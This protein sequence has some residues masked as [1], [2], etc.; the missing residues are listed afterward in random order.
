[1]KV[2]KNNASRLKRRINCGMHW[3]T[4]TFATGS[5]KWTSTV[6]PRML[7]EGGI[8]FNRERYD[9]L[10]QSGIAAERGTA[11][12]Y[13]NVRRSDNSL[14]YI[15]GASAAQ[16]GNYPDRYNLTGS[17][18]YVTG[19]HS[20]KAGFIDGFGPYRRYNNAN[21]DLYQIYNNLAPLQVSVLN[22]RS[23]DYV[24]QRLRRRIAELDICINTSRGRGFI[25]YVDDR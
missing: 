3:N 17:A 8:S 10:Y 25:I 16:L 1:M 21:A 12:W 13:Q 19:S 11:K 4:P 20:V 9:N 5:A 22:T 18:S 2:E 24:V 6:T 23:L 14:G 15:W 7:V